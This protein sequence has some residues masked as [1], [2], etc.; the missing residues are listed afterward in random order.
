[1]T[2][3]SEFNGGSEI[4]FWCIR[5]RPTGHYLPEP[6]GR[7]GR[8]GS[9]VEPVSPN[10]KRPRL[11]STKLAAQRALSAWL[12]GKFHHSSGYDSFTDEYWEKVDLEP[13]SARNKDDMDIICVSAV[14]P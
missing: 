7:M 12:R 8:G 5:H 11:F 9:H 4:V 10:E 13:V 2:S 3:E 6:E 14:L 1:M